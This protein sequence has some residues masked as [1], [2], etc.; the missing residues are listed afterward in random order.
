MKQLLQ[1]EKVLLYI[2]GIIGLL[3]FINL[4]FTDLQVWDEPLYAVRAEAM[5]RFGDWLDQ[6]PH[7]IEGLYS[8]L[9]PPLYVW[10]TAIAYRLFGI[11]E[12]STRL[13]SAL[14]GAGTIFFVY[15]I[16]K[17]IYN[18]ETGFIAALFL[19][20]NP[21]YT[22]WTR[23]GQLDATLTFFITLSFF[24]ICHLASNTRHA[25]LWVTLSGT[26][27]GFAL[28]TKLFVAIV[29]PV[30]WLLT[31]IISYQAHIK[32]TLWHVLLITAVAVL[33]A[34]P[35]HLMITVRHGN[36]DVLFFLNQSAMIQR[37]FFGIEGNVKE[38]GWLYYVNQLIVVIPYALVF[39][40]YGFYEI[41]RGQRNA[42]S[43]SI[44]ETRDSSRTISDADH[45]NLFAQRIIALWSFTFFI[46]FTLIRTKLAVYTLPMLVPI[47]LIS[48]SVVSSLRQESSGGKGTM[49]LLQQ[50]VSRKSAAILCL[51]TMI[52]VLWAANHSW[53]VAIK[54][55][56]KAATGS[57]R[58]TNSDST[59]AIFFFLLL[60]ASCI[61]FLL[62]YRKG[63]LHNLIQKYL[64]PA[65]VLPL[66]LIFAFN[67]FI[68]D[69]KQY[70]DGA[71]AL[72]EFLKSRNYTSI[73]VVGNGV[74]PQ[75]TYY[76]DGIDVGWHKDRVFQ[77]L[78]PKDGIQNIKRYLSE[79]KKR[80][81]YLI[82]EKD[83]MLLGSYTSVEEVLPAGYNK[84]FESRAYMVFE[85]Q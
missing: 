67:I 7:S 72:A 82:I 46:V 15:L 78:Q 12:F 28:M 62:L 58:S 31:S 24:F 80:D 48:A 61:L 40:I 73:I 84:I 10:F 20:L 65:I 69:T 41:F 14:F 76:L 83:E 9:H 56:F 29:V 63:L 53:R 64:V 6:T 77:R 19:G 8:S 4:G 21:F 23:Q 26:A 70:D 2:I 32:R 44:K 43:V 79:T 74:N 71:K 57:V 52:N 33:I 34:L 50:T 38:L 1:S 42:S 27:I 37:T 75:L 66:L 22:F 81:F 60:L 45:E 11:N 54:N 39:F 35:W 85:R 17:Q 13:F 47:S 55:V 25:W 68:L 59:Q 16:G 5:V 49:P 30:I 51:L 36:G 3:R 18:R